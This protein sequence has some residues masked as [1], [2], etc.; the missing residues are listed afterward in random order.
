MLNSKRVEI[1]EE[2]LLEWRREIGKRNPGFASTA[3]RFIIHVGDVHDAVHLIAAQFEMSLQ[4]VL[5]DISAE[6]SDVRAT[7]NSRS[8][9]VDADLA[10]SWI[11][12]L[13]LFE[14]PRVGVK[15]TQRHLDQWSNGVKE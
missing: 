9:C 10:G 8:A 13:E 1:F 14:L 12:R 6:V 2:C 4:Q 5:E 7:V 3:N 11:A 15:E